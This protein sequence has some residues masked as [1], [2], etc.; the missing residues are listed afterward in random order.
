MPTPDI[1]VVEE[2]AFRNWLEKET[3][4]YAMEDKWDHK[5]L[6][7]MLLKSFRAGIKYEQSLWEDD[8]K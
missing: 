1:K 7:N 5:W 4:E 8:C 6:T 2:K 3:N